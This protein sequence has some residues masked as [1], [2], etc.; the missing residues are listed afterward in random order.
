MA[1]PYFTDPTGDAIEGRRGTALADVVVPEAVRVPGSEQ[2]IALENARF[3]TGILLAGWSYNSRSDQPAV[4]A[5][6]TPGEDRYLI[7][8]HFTGTG[9]VRLQFGDTLGESVADQNEDLSTAFESVGEIEVSFDGTDYV[10]ELAGADLSE[11]YGW[12]PSNSADVIALYN[13]L[14]GATNRAATLT[15]RDFEPG[16]PPQPAPTYAAV[17]AL[18]AGVTFTPAT[19]TLS[20]NDDEFETSSGTIRIRAENSEG[21]ADWTVAY[22]FTSSQIYLGGALVD[23]VYLGGT[24]VDAVYIGTERVL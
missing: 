15:L 16:S 7:Y 18:P 19:R 11:P 8:I 20:F 14:L 4:D 13:A 2:S 1:A 10:F 23:R 24:R 5:G 17:G 3:I 6:L 22:T 12:G 9:Q 21:S